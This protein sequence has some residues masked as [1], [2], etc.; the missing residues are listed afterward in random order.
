MSLPKAKREIGD[1]N[2]NTEDLQPR[3]QNGVWS[4]EMCNVSD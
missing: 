3:Y 4:Q 2:I 1:P